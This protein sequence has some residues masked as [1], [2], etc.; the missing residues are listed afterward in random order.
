MSST[1]SRLVGALRD[2]HDRLFNF[3][4]GLGATDLEQI[5]YCDEW[6]VA[7]VLS[8]IGSAAE[9]GRASL[10][11]ALGEGEPLDHAGQ[12]AV[13]DRWNNKTPTEQAADAGASDDALVGLLEGLEPEQLDTLEVPMEAMSFSS[14]DLLGL[15]LG[16]RALHAWDVEV[17]S[18]PSVRIRPE[19][20]DLLL[21]VVPFLTPW[22]AKPDSYDGP[23]KVAISTSEPAAQFLLTLDGQ[24]SLERLAEPAQAE[25][26][27]E[28]PAE[29]LVRLLYGRLDEEHA[30]SNIESSG[31][32][33][34]QLRR[35]FPGP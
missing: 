23:T 2:V 9:I 27:I 5:S 21:D 16:E 29:A 11:A 4:T 8:H 20:V 17:V 6:T 26:S 10:E 35:A 24:G 34:D 3:V 22:F 31:V 19:H 25:A 30:P 7:Q 32:G 14:R 15:F 12:E 1:P 28:L 13:W 18:D 33:L